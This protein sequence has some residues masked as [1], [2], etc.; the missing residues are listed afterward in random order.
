MSAEYNAGN[1]E[2][3]YGKISL[4]GHNW[5][6]HFLMTLGYVL[7]FWF[8]HI[9]LRISIKSFIIHSKFR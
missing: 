4:F 5:K 2:Y 9:L 3:D 1:D 7:E 8:N 6:E